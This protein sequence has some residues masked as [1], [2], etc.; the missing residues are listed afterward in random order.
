MHSH[1][2]NKHD[3]TMTVQ[4]AMARLKKSDSTIRRYMRENQ[5]HYK[6][7]RRGRFH[8]YVSDVEYLAEIDAIEPE[9]QS[10]DQAMI[11][12]LEDRIAS[13]EQRLDSQ[14]AIL[15]SMQ[16]RLNGPLGMYEEVQSLHEL[17]FRQLVPKIDKLSLTS[18]SSPGIIGTKTHVKETRPAGPRT[19]GKSK[20]SQLAPLPAGWASWNS[21]LTR[22][23]LK[24]DKFTED[25][26]DYVMTGEEYRYKSSIVRYPLDYAGQNHF[27]RDYRD[28]VSECD[29]DECPCHSLLNP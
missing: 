5:L 10:V 29:V 26:E 13:L 28:Q 9:A 17:V 15:E 1:D 27:I 19:T 6:K 21:F 20:T 8:I 24:A 7:D 23:G 11:S 4:E 12:R 2:H 18:V 16:Q 14:Q 25:R 22:H 3:P